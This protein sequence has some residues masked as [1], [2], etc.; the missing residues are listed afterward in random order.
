[1]R[2]EIQV[3]RRLSTWRSR[4]RLVLTQ[5]LALMKNPQNH[6]TIPRLFHS[7]VNPGQKLAEAI[8]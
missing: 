8:S 1:M 2:G 6:G 3:A 7:M 4:E 5:A